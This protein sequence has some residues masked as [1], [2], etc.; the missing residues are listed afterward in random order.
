MDRCQAGAEKQP[1][2]KVRH[3]HAS[4]AYHFCAELLD[5]VILYI[6]TPFF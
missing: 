2:D 4:M 3:T 6:G 5:A 1:K